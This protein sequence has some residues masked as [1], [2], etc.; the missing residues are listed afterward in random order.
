M[1]EQIKPTIP[2]KRRRIAIADLLLAASTIVA[3]VV[4]VAMTDPKIP[5][6]V[7]D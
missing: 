4:V 6:G 3:A 2:E 7:G 5:A 1:S